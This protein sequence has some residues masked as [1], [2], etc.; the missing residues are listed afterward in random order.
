ML[1]TVA[2][3]G[4]EIKTNPFF[5]L[6]EI[7]KMLDLVHSG[8]MAGKGVIVVSEEEQKKVRESGT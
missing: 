5:G 2:E 8:K 3:H 7:P 4:I 1:N 6:T